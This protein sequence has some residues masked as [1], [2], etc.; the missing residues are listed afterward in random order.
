MSK[1]N[2]GWPE[3]GMIVKN[4]VKDKDG[5]VVKDSKGEP[6]TRLAFKLA[7]NVTILVDGEPVTLNKYRTGILKSPVEEVEGLYKSGAI[8]DGDIEKRRESAK[9]AHTWLRYKVQLP[10]P[11]ADQE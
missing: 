5:N 3:L 6:V 2:K 4:T 7:E 11:K 1:K 8:G 10:P 9:A